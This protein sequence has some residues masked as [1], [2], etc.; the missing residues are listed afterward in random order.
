LVIYENQLKAAALTSEGR[1]YTFDEF[2]EAAR[3][4]VD[5]N[6]NGHVD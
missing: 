1:S 2:L 5:G 4:A 3:A 6:H